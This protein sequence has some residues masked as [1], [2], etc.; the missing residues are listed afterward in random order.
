MAGR[1]RSAVTVGRSGRTRPAP[2]APDE[3]DKAIIRALQVDGR[4]SYAKLGPEVGL[5]QAAV[6][7][8]VQRLID[9]GV[10]QVVAVTDPLSLGFTV[11]A[12]IGVRADGDLRALAANLGDLGEIDYVVIASGGFDLLLEVVCEDADHL[13]VLLNDVIRV[14]PGVRSAEAFTYLDLVKQTYSWGTR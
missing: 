14:T 2:P 8:R 13:M 5:S 10:M 3:I 12:M 4:M 1:N 11:Q 9:S 7:Q 6:R